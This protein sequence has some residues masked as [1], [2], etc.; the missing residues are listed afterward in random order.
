MN[1]LIVT[2]GLPDCLFWP[3]FRNVASFQLIC[4]KYCIWPFLPHLKSVGLKKFVWPVG[5]FLALLRWNRFFW[6]KIL[7]LHVFRQHI[8][9]NFVI[10]VK[11][12]RHR[13]SVASN[14]WGLWRSQEFCLGG[15]SHWQRQSSIFSY[16]VQRSFRCRI[17]ISDLLQQDMTSNI[18]TSRY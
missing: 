5:S 1:G 9:K 2:A 14:T 13:R 8:S 6:G 18:L 17:P 4:L 12:N 15:A 10:N 16:F 11:L 7:L 3:N